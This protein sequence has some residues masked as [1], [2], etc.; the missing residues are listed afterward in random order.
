IPKQRAAS[1]LNTLIVALNQRNMLLVLDNCE[2]LFP[3]CATIIET[4][5]Q[6]CPDLHILTTSREPLRVAEEIIW[7][8]P[9][10]ALPPADGVL[11]PE[12]IARFSAIELF[13]QRAKRVVND[14]AITAA[15]AQII[16]N[17]C[18]KL[19]GM[20]LALELA[21]VR[22]AVLAPAQL[23]RQLEAGIAI[24]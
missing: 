12:Q 5:W 15:N 20:P 14:F 18:R 4:L 21:A 8:V 9:S 6:Q 2:H 10:L 3:T 22:L 23:L 17:I 13:V 11:A 7:R 1:P 24:L 16:V 19:D